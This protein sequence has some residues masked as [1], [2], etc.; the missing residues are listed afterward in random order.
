VRVSGTRI[1][2]EYDAPNFYC[3]D[4]G[5]WP[6]NYTC[7]NDILTSSDKLAL[8][9]NGQL[10]PQVQAWIYYDY[11]TWDTGVDM[12]C[13]GSGTYKATITYVRQNG[14]VPPTSDTKSFT[15]QAPCGTPDRGT[16]PAG[17]QGRGPQSA[18]GQPINIGS[19]DVSTSISLFALN[20]SPL[21]LA[22][23]LSYHSSPSAYPSIAVPQP[24][25]IGWTHAFNQ[26]L[27]PIPSTNR[28]L[29]L[30]AD[31]REFEFTQSGSIW[32][33]SRP[34]ESRGT[35]ST[36]VDATKCPTPT[37]TCYVL[38]DLDG[39]KTFFDYDGSYAGRWRRTE[40]RWQ[41]KIAG[42]WSGSTQTITDMIGRTIT[43]TFGSGV[44]QSIS[45][46]ETPA[47]R[48]WNFSYNT[49]NTLLLWIRDPDPRHASTN[50]RNL[51]YDAGNRLASITDDASKAIEGHTYDTQGRGVTSYSEGG[52]RNFVK[53]EYDTPNVGERRVTHHIDS[54][55]SLDQVSYFNLVYQG[56]R[57]LPVNIEG[58]CTTC[59][60][61]TGD[62]QS[63]TYTAD[64][65][66]Y[67]ATDGKGNVTEFGYNTDGNVTSMIEAKGPSLQRMTTWTYTY[68]SWPN[69]WTTMSVP[70]TSSGSKTTTR[71]WGSGETALTITETGYSS[72]ASKTYT[73][74]ETYGTKHRLSTV[75]GPRTD[76]NDTTALAYYP[77]TPVI[78]NAGRL[79]TSTDAA[80]L[81]T[82]YAAYDIYGTAKNVT[83]ANGVLAT[84]TTDEK[85]RVAGKSIAPVAG[86][87]DQTT[88]ST[89]YHFDSRDR[90][91]LVTLNNGNKTAYI[92]EDGT[93][94]LTAT[95]REDSAGHQLE[96]LLLTLNDIGGKKEEDAQEC[97]ASPQTTDCTANWTPRRSEKFT[98]DSKNHLMQVVHPLP[99]PA[100][101]S[102]IIYTYDPN[103]LLWSV[104]DERHASANTTYAYDALNRLSV[105]T[106]T[107]AGAPSNQITTQYGYDVQD[108]QTSVT[109]PNAS[110]TTYVYDDF[111]RM[112]SQSSPASGA[113]TYSYDEAGNLIDSTDANGALTHRTYDAQNR[114]LTASSTRTGYATDLVTNTWGG[115]GSMAR[116]SKGRLLS[117]DVQVG[118]ASKVTTAYGYERRGLLISENQTVLG[119]VS[120][121]GY[122][123]DGN[124]NRTA[125][126]YPSGRVVNYGFDFA[127]R[128][129]S[130]TSPSP[131]R[132]YVSA[133]SYY[134]F[135]PEK[136]LTYG[137]AT[138]WSLTLNT[139]YQPTGMG[140]SGVS[141]VSY[142]YAPDALGNITGITDN[143]NANYNRSFGYDDLNR[144]TTATTGSALWGATGLLTYG[145]TF[146][147]GSTPT[148]DNLNRRRLQLGSRDV[149]YGYDAVAGHWSTRLASESD[150]SPTSV[151]R[152]AAGG[153]TSFGGL[154]SGYSARNLM[155][156]TGTA[157]FYYNAGGVR[158]TQTTPSSGTLLYTVTPC[159][160]F[161]TRSSVGAYGGPALVSGGTRTFSIWGQCGIPTSATA[162]T[163]NLT[164]PGAGSD[165]YLKLFPSDV[166]QPTAT[167]IS[168]QAGRSRANNGIAKLS[169][170]GQ[171]NV[172]NGATVDT[173]AILDVS[174]YFLASPSFRQSYFYSPELH[175]LSETTTSLTNPS[176]AIEYVWFGSRPIAQESVTDSSA[177][178][179][180]VSDHLGT[181]FLATNATPAISWRVEYEPFG[182]AYGSPR[183][184]TSS[185]V[186]L[187]FPGQELRDTS[188][189]RYYNIFRW[190]RPDLGAYTQPDP[191]RNPFAVKE[192]PYSYVAG[193]P[194]VLRDPL[195]LTP[196]GPCCQT[197]SQR[198][199]DKQRILRS[200]NMA[201]FT[202][203]STHMHVPQTQCET[204]GAIV[205]TAIA[206]ANPTCFDW[207]DVFSE[208]KSWLGFFSS[209]YNEPAHTAT[210]LRPCGKAAWPD[211]TIL[212]A[213]PG[214]MLREFPWSGWKPGGS[215][216]TPMVYDPNGGGRGACPFR[217]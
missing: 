147:I 153:E 77:D 128:P 148:R 214:G 159:R 169:A 19:G 80:G 14:L 28:L 75:D 8:Y 152:D 191:L 79:N 132:T 164:V 129:S 213:W 211:G 78:N 160:V 215:V 42:A 26:Y 112:T 134:P 5:D 68:P 173:H 111:R 149:S 200:I 127:D 23:N 199:S 2:V 92:Y 86:D 96:R 188:P 198:D 184:G 158:V 157:G 84:L 205:S 175:L 210:V 48:V 190:Y 130:A 30:T 195:G 166:S 201:L 63:F 100:D 115:T 117:A 131:A 11:G 167:V 141:G 106:Q 126:T 83:D 217:P 142:T 21:P 144:L 107:L 212:D 120:S 31:G 197:D 65:H 44:I 145:G 82:T 54:S 72:G 17:G 51:S 110:A 37:S 203:N 55:L 45:I 181:P 66:V 49:G 7:N 62:T 108:N 208:E 114:L 105:V 140:L 143:G 99:L 171:V 168:F 186:R 32:N 39:G 85:G 16:C 135:G 97:T 64:N 133:A 176:P 27:T 207:N 90:L 73:T 59:G 87:P 172:F 69:F 53:V 204:Y 216:Y 138:V 22:M 3:K 185:D 81:I 119:T 20:T 41:N 46:P 71:T 162:V 209:Y 192:G 178:K 61:A 36:L 93:N 25:G 116:Y 57:W 187:R 183:A 124:G 196:C 98:Y 137:N 189:G 60:G 88:Y 58:N 161:D 47:A 33:A 139:R 102:K 193:N 56:G 180:L 150:L 155:A 13:P 50:W 156:S 163:M 154:A 174:G 179:Y 29:Y 10:D 101:S 67:Q 109:D 1:L 170:S 12:P 194:L 24:L 52:T 202:Y 6:P 123:Y 94:R 15:L 104:Q 146:N 182:N 91:D 125:M 103:G 151:S 9:V 121:V 40:D 165:G 74:I 113:T 35:V 43:I 76:V 34:A 4:T 70:S 89:A 122:Q 206:K 136:S 118:G 38:T 18:A 95:I 177:L